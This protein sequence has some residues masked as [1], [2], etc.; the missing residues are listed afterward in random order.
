MVVFK[1]KIGIIALFATAL[2][3]VPAMATTYW[4]DN[5]VAESGDGLTKETAF[6]TW[7]E[8]L[9]NF[10][11]LTLSA[12]AELNVVASETPY[13]V[14]AAPTGPRGYYNVA[15]I[16]GVNAD[17][18]DVDDP[19]SVVIDGQGLYQ[20]A[21]CEQAIGLTISGL[22]FANASSAAGAMSNAGSGSAIDLKEYGSNT[23]TGG[24]VVSNCV[25][26]GCSGGAALLVVGSSNTVTHC[27][28]KGNASTFV[29]SLDI[30]Q[31]KRRTDLPSYVR[32]CRFEGNDGS[33]A[34]SIYGAGNALFTMSVLEISDCVFKGNIGAQNGA[35]AYLYNG[36]A[37]TVSGCDFIANTN[38]FEYSKSNQY[39]GIVVSDYGDAAGPVFRECTFADNVCELTYGA[40]RRGT[41]GTH[42]VSFYDCTFDGN[43]S[44]LGAA[45]GFASAKQLPLVS[46]CVFR[47]NNAS[48]AGGSVI[49]IPSGANP[50]VLEECVFESN[51]GGNLIAHTRSSGQTPDELRRCT[52][53]GNALEGTTHNAAVVGSF[54]IDRCAFTNNV[55][56]SRPFINVS[57]DTSIAITNSIFADNG[58]GGSNSSS[59][60][61]QFIAGTCQ[62]DFVNCTFV[63]NKARGQI[64]AFYGSYSQNLA[65]CLFFGNASTNNEV[66]ISS[67]NSTTSLDYCF[68]D[69]AA[70][71]GIAFGAH[72]VGGAGATPGF[73][74]A[75]NG[76]YALAKNSVCRNA[77]DNTAW[78]G[79]A[80]ATDLAGKAR[81]NADD[82]N[83][84]DIGCYEWYSSRLP[85]MVIF[86]R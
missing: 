67:Q 62:G 79:I 12:Y 34:T 38:T 51:G 53:A 65:N 52:F 17:G 80:G 69:F 55:H 31:G 11:S 50:V 75:A 43:R 7:N 74:D 70:P 16:R 54:R 6:K 60:K 37:A 26:T 2:F 72:M 18:T 20:I 47:A 48:K 63:N 25:F 40:F 5:S 32:N 84:V 21:P 64:L 81:I 86:V 73:A 45:I 33:T 42:P 30:R 1:I 46:N 56:L 78:A 13:V 3:A 8:A 39:G 66:V 82:G 71:S 59:G 41:S 15:R 14:T 19:A 22:T 49:D 76:D 23:N 24:N 68:T 44:Q 57:K 27:V 58:V 35:A 4:L 10:G 85:G 77:G 9:A 61:S 36:Y 28:F 29:S 83:V